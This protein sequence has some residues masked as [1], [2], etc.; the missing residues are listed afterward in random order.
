MEIIF[1]IRENHLKGLI[2]FCFCGLDYTL[3]NDDVQ[4]EDGWCVSL[5]CLTTVGPTTTGVIIYNISNIMYYIYLILYIINIYMMCVLAVMLS[6]HCE[7][8]STLAC[9]HPN[10]RAA[11]C[12]LGMTSIL[13]S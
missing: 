2:T 13:Q 9:V 8:G 5:L 1:L 3:T 7:A 11:T 10:S 4:P 12:S 6:L